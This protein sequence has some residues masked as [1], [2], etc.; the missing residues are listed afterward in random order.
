M[1]HVKSFHKLRGYA[2]QERVYLC[3]TVNGKWVESWVYEIPE[4]R[5]EDAFEKGGFYRTTEIGEAND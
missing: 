5:I 4:S 1:P 3:E 2:K